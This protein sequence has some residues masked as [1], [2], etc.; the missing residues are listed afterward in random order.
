VVPVA[1]ADVELDG[2]AP[3]PSGLALDANERLPVVK[4]EVIAG[5]LAETNSD[6]VPSLP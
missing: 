6:A 5:V 1:A 4:D 2:A 3:E